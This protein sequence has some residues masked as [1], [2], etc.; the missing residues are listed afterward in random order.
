MTTELELDRSDSLNLRA[1][2]G[3]HQPFLTSLLP[4]LVFEG[5]SVVDI[6]AH[7]GYFTVLFSGL[8]GPK[9]TVLAYEPAP[10]TFRTLKENLAKN[11]CKNAIAVKMAVGAKTTVEKLYLCP[12]NIG[13]NRLFDSNGRA[14]LAVDAVKLDDALLHLDHIDLIKVDVQGF[15]GFVFQG[16]QQI[17]LLMTRRIVFE[18]WPTGLEKSGFGARRT[19]NLLQDAGFGF[20]DLREAEGK[21]VPVTAEELME[22]YKPRADD[23]P[24]SIRQEDFTDVLAMREPV[25]EIM[26]MIS[27]AQNPLP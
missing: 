8:A 15:E 10:V 4:K 19:L 21:V 25:E 11:N 12:E 20:F 22:R 26:E 27:E 1:S 16:A 3:V 7:I 23:N 2:G 17:V 18:F 9:G 13:D 5:S 24:D 6:G 14:W